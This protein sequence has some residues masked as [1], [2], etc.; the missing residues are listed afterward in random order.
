[1]ARVFWGGGNPKEN[2]MRFK[3]RMFKEEGI[4][5]VPCF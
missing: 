3:G 1:M 2:G 4:D 5:S